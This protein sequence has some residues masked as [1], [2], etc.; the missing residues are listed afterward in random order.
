MAAEYALIVVQAP[1]VT[2]RWRATIDGRPALVSARGEVVVRALPAV[3]R[4]Q[5]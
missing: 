1:G 2:A 5:P 3:V 4:L